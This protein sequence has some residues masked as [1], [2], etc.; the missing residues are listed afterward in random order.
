MEAHIFGALLPSKYFLGHVKILCIF[1]YKYVFAYW[2]LL[3]IKCTPNAKLF[4]L[5]APTPQKKHTLCNVGFR[6]FFSNIGFYTVSSIIASRMSW[7]ILK[8]PC[9]ICSSVSVDLRK[10]YNTKCF[11]TRYCLLLTLLNVKQK[12]HN[13]LKYK[14]CK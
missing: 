7:S 12:V 13:F 8:G 6:H 5:S 10:N 3:V 14:I 4:V 11:H 9:F 2:S 1:F